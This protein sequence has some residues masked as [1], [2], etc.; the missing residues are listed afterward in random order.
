MK[1][2]TIPLLFLLA[3][4]VYAQGWSTHMELD[5]QAAGDWFGTWVAPG[6]DLDGDGLP[7]LLVGAG[8]ADGAVGTDAGV[9]YVLAGSDGSVIH[10]WEGDE[11]YDHFGGRIVTAGDVDGDGYDDIAVH[12]S[13][14]LGYRTYGKVYVFSG[15]TG[16]KLFKVQGSGDHEYLG[17]GLGSLGDV[18][19]DGYDDIVAGS[20][21]DFPMGVP[22]YI[23]A[24][25]GATGLEVW[26][27]I[28][29]AT[30]SRFGWSLAPIADLDGD[31]ITDLIGS[32]PNNSI[33][34]GDTG[35]VY[36]YSGA[37][38]HL[39]DQVSGTEP[40]ALLGTH[41]ASAGDVNGDGVADVIA[42]AL[43]ADPGGRSDAGSVY[44]FSGANLSDTLFRMDGPASSD[45]M[46]WTV[47]GGVDWNADGIPDFA[48]G[49]P[50]T[51]HEWSTAL[52]AV[53]LFS[54]KDGNLFQTLAGTDPG[55]FF[56]GG[57][58]AL[59]DVSGD[60]SADLLVSGRF[61]DSSGG[62]DSGQV[63][64]FA[65]P[66]TFSFSV[67]GLSPGQPATLSASGCRP[68]AKVY[69]VYSLRGEGTIWTRYGFVLSLADPVHD[70]PPIITGAAG[71]GYV[72]LF[73]PPH[74][75]PGLR[76]LWQAVERWQN[77]GQDEYRVANLLETTVQ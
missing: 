19:G 12:A 21:G 63:T 75:P 46:G 49:A 26:R 27:A 53:Y 14:H 15:Q 10:T 33:G 34:G 29:P 73:V 59:N 40:G 24:F 66:G 32:A 11:I 1:S 8:N 2:A 57:V 3:P 31:G 30:G 54:G 7:E 47:A 41:V 74:A 42:S 45:Y 6:P 17:V 68:N 23:A 65:S 60:G 52:G 72:I 70:L 28:G 9:A 25:S 44:V 77:G 36:L 69:P 58:V 37:D 39:L 4:L 43:Y 50:G 55:G 5:G 61:V 56:G 64:V 62:V 35:T 48:C 76:V 38:G 67:Q 20:Y 51:T 22:G 13:G 16:A 18:D 71:S